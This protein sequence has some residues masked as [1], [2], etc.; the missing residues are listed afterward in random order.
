M[1]CLPKLEQSVLFQLGDMAATSDHLH[2][3]LEFFLTERYCLGKT[4][5]LACRVATPTA[6][7]GFHVE[8]SS[9]ISTFTFYF[10]IWSK[11]H[12]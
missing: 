10:E 9:E 5:A 8:N 2:S 4:L 11:S 7:F 12:G 6:S 1:L 3:I